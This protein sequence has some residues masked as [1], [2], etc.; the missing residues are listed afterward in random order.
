MRT[1]AHRNLGRTSLIDPDFPTE[2]VYRVHIA[3]DACPNP[4]KNLQ[5]QS[6]LS[7]TGSIKRKAMNDVMGV[8]SIKRR[9]VTLEGAGPMELEVDR[10][11][12]DSVNLDVEPMEVVEHKYF[13]PDHARFDTQIT[14]DVMYAV[15][16]HVY[17]SHTIVTSSN[18]GWIPDLAK[19]GTIERNPGEDRRPNTQRSNKPRSSAAGTKPRRTDLG[20]S[21]DSGK[22]QERKWKKVNKNGSTG[23]SKGKLQP[24][25]VAAVIL[26][27]QIKNNQEETD[28][29]K[30]ALKE[31][32]EEI[33]EANLDLL[34][35]DDAKKIE[36][37]VVVV[38]N[39][40]KLRPHD[41]IYF[42][43]EGRALL[44]DEFPSGRWCYTT[45]KTAESAPVTLWK[46][47]KVSFETFSQYIDNC[48]KRRDGYVP[49][50]E[51]SPSP[52]TVCVEN[53]PSSLLLEVDGKPV[54]VVDESE[55]VDT[56]SIPEAPAQPYDLTRYR[57]PGSH[58]S[59]DAAHR[60]RF[61]Y[62]KALASKSWYM[63]FMVLAL[64]WL[65][66]FITPDLWVHG[67]AY[68]II[69]YFCIPATFTTVFLLAYSLAE[70]SVTGR[71]V[72]LLKPFSR[73]DRR[74]DTQSMKEL[75]REDPLIAR[76]VV[77]K[78]CRILGMHITYSRTI[79]TMS[80]EL[81][82]QMSTARQLISSADEKQ[83]RLRLENFAATFQ[84]D[85]ID[86]YMSLHQVNIAQDS[87]YIALC[88][89]RQ[90]QWRSKWQDF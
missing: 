65:M 33:A 69:K 71:T 88:L 35:P 52:F 70:M 39:T 19:E 41:R 51:E 61:E 36:P 14:T 79:V 11:D 2:M 73:E 77:S 72:A 16:R 63:W 37:A 49:C 28:G 58:T 46:K 66:D 83:T 31:K 13:A 84:G 8:P 9:I 48:R 43:E 60:F 44:Y 76:I 29:L 47:W 78:A 74:A 75:M 1:K 67:L 50:D 20:S 12:V 89:F 59:Q 81:L 30:D 18:G 42:T 17:S 64:S 23:P 85:N 40:K 38:N 54:V 34:Y 24:A 90:L 45:R 82:T 32:L 15:I 86:R 53:I 5:T 26:S 57:T 21:T 27:E 87:A 56:D 55:S 3:D 10:M 68:N 80:M 7:C 4:M 6:A 25:N 22:S 62:R